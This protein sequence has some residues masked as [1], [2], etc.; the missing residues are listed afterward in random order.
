M[1]LHLLYSN[2]PK[3]SLSKIFLVFFSTMNNPQILFYKTIPFLFNQD[4]QP[5]SDNLPPILTTTSW[6][7]LASI[8]TVK[9][10]NQNQPQSNLNT[11]FPDLF[12]CLFTTHHVDNRTTTSQ[13]GSSFLIEELDCSPILAL[14]LLPFF[15]TL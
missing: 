2:H 14:R 1:S 11:T 8:F 5:L 10:T 6:H 3:I 9:D 4:N 13:P 12:K 15:T 7:F